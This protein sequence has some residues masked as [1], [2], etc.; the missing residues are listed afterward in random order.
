[1]YIQ[2]FNILERI[3]GNFHAVQFSQM[4]SLQSFLFTD[5]CDHA[6]YTLYIRIYFAGLISRIAA[7][8]RKLSELIDRSEHWESDT[9]KV[10]RGYHFWKG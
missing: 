6:Y 2:C 3:P 10:K 4:A 8:S 7:Y 9:F 5:A 1:M